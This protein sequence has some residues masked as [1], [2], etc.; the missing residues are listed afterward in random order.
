MIGFV[1]VYPEALRLFSEVWRQHAIIATGVKIHKGNG[2]FRPRVVSALSR[3]GPKSLRPGLFRPESFR[4][5]VVSATFG[6][7]F[8]NDPDS[9]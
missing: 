8:R 2:S 6:G 1:Q 7:S 5:Y 4:P 3:F 9:R